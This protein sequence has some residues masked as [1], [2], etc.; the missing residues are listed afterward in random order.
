MTALRRRAGLVVACGSGGGDRSRWA[1][2]SMSVVLAV[3]MLL[4]VC[5]VM[6]E[7]F[8]GADGAWAQDSPASWWGLNATVA[9][10]NVPRDGQAQFVVTATDLGF[11]DVNGTGEDG[12]EGVTLTDELP[13][14]F[15]AVGVVGGFARHSPSCQ[16]VGPRLV[17]CTFTGVLAPYEELGVRITAASELGGGPVPV[18]LRNIV[19]IEGGATPVPP[20]FEEPV[21]IDDA[22]TPFGV[23]SYALTPEDEAGARDTLAGSHPFQL[24]TTLDL[25]E[26]L[27]DYNSGFEKGFFPSAPA[28][29]R[30]LRFKLP[31]GLVADTTAVAQC[32]DLNF[33]TLSSGGES[34]VTN[35]CPGDSALGVASVLLNMPTP[36]KFASRTVPVFNL[37]PGPGEPARL[38]FEVEE[39]P[40]VL[41]VS[42]PAGG[43]YAAEVSTTETS[44]AAQLLSSLV[45]IW[46]APGDARHNSSRGWECLEGGLFEAG[47]E[48]QVRCPEEVNAN[49][50][51]F[52]TLPTSC[53]PLRSNVS[54][55]SWTTGE[56]GDEG[57]GL[58]SENASFES[59][60]R[61]TGCESLA[62]A[63]SVGTQPESEAASTPS[64]LDVGVSM[65]QPG[66]TQS[67]GRAEAAVKQTTV[68]LPEGVQLNPAA[69]NGLEDCG[70]LQ[71]GFEGSDEEE[72]MLNRVFS[73]GTPD[74]PDAAKVG[75]VEISTPLLAEELSGSVYLAAQNVS[76]FHSPL[77][78]YLVAEDHE[79]GILVKLVGE[80]HV[81]EATGQVITTFKNTPQLPF[82][83][84]KIHLFG[85]PR[86][87]FSTP[88]HCGL[89]TTE[90]TFTPWSGQ[91]DAN[92]R[93]GL[94]VSAGVG[95][96]PCPP[97]PLVFGP[98]FQARSGNPQ[99]GAFSPFT[100]TLERPDGQQALTGV[101]VHLPM[102]VAAVLASVSSCPEPPP[103]QEWGCGPGSLIG[104]SIAS[105]GLGGEPV[106]L[107]GQVYLT[108][109]YDGAPFGLLVQTPAVAG[110]FDL[111]MVNVR[112]HIN[113]DPHDASVTVTTDPGPRNETLPTRLRG[114]PAQLKQVKIYVDRSGFAFNPTNCTPTHIEA[115]LTGD[116]GAT[117]PL[118]YPFNPTGCAS[119]P[120]KPTLDASTLGHASKANGTSLVVKVTSQGLGVANIQKVDLQLP[121]QL[122]SRLTTIQKAC[123]AAVFQATP[124]P[125]GACPEGS[126]IG[127]ATIHTP[128]FNHP[129]T[130][131]AYLVS[132]GGAAFPDVEFVLRGE[133]V[134]I[135]LDGQTDIKKGITYS[136]F[137]SAPDAPFTTFEAILP[138]GP[139]S[140]LTANVRESKHYDLC[141]EKLTLPTTI[142]A[143]NGATTEQKTKIAIQGC[144]QVK[145]AKT[146]KL[147]RKQLLAKALKACHKRFRHDEHKRRSCERQA[148]K[149]YASPKDRKTHKAHKAQKSR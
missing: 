14:G 107:S 86:A 123:P 27:D 35:M 67:E 43:E 84:L 66:L 134:T 29:P 39:V 41:D 146:K 62:F 63:P 87:A 132:H 64:G 82:A 5:A 38:G 28:L 37:V 125:G 85:G 65:P 144:A 93:A 110:P 130:G 33:T 100:V 70:A 58:A 44:Q 78:I 52:L 95:G 121:K 111:G 25:N 73:S 15:T 74:C 115:T 113:V 19:R 9:P 49:P 109:G 136:R 99:A 96:G 106:S 75:T 61:L 104:H 55:K 22:P 149:K 6:F 40:V 31:P 116:E 91:P 7:A 3:V 112:S 92:P 81:D 127:S 45:T 8:L 34:S 141:G 133:G 103:G 147:T 98:G 69:A 17:S 18:G 72:Q 42:L 114:V 94:T 120:F 1:G 139:H 138:T 148:R 13:Q 10:T 57:Q 89:Y 90:S 129:L 137:E 79:R 23:E 145:S 11:G 71:F 126:Q 48:P 80:V 12:G 56:P 124:T 26:S 60:H 140:A 4:V 102:G 50:P 97:G 83:Q 122:P 53:E 142:T 20:A 30:N 77:A 128:I 88:A 16:L 2:A 46:G 32:S 54:G 135:V 108:S 51:A 131:P 76:P 59:A 24:T 21:K 68:S 36:L 143:Q 47:R 105:A 117:S 119:L 101:S 118:S